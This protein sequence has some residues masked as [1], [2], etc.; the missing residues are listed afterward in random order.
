MGLQGVPFPGTWLGSG[1]PDL[2][3]FKPSLLIGRE[4]Q[5]RVTVPT[6]ATMMDPTI[7]LPDRR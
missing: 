4:I 6:K 5:T 1:L 7:P 3:V 2:L